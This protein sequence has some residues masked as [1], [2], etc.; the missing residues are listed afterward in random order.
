MNEESRLKAQGRLA[1]C[2]EI[3]RSY[4][5]MVQAAPH[6]LPGAA[7]QSECRQAITLLDR[8]QERLDR[9]LIVTIVGP[10]GAGKS[11]LLNA[12]AGSDDLSPV[13]IE[14]PTTRGVTVF[15]QS[16]SDADILLRDLGHE[17]VT[18]RTGG[19]VADGLD[20]VLLV[21]TPDMDS[22]ESQS[23]RTALEKTINMSDVLFC[24]L[25]AENPKRR[26]TIV[27]MR[28][29]VDLYPGNQLCVVLNRCDRL[30]ETELKQVILPD[31][32]KHLQESW[33]RPVEFVFCI[34]ARNNLQQP[35]WPDGEQPLHAY[36]DY[37]HLHEYVFGSLNRG[38]RFVDTRIERAEHLVD[39]I[40]KSAEDSVA[41]TEEKLK[42]VKTE[43][44]DLEKNAILAA[45]KTMQTTG[46]AMITGIHAIFYQKLAGRWWGPIG[47]LVGVWTRFLMAGAGVLATMRFG[48][49]VV[50]IWGLISSLVR[51]RKTRKA[52]TEAAAGGDMAPVLLKYRYTLQT[53]WPD[54][55]RKL[56]ELGFKPA[57]RDV[58]TVIPADRDLTRRLTSSWESTF[59]SVLDR[60]AGALSGFLLQLFFNLPTLALMGMFAYQSVK[61]YLFQQ[62]LPSGYFLH[63]G[64]SIFLVWILSFVLLQILVRF[65]GGTGLLNRAFAILVKEIQAGDKAGGSAALVQEIDTVLKLRQ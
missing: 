57:V 8:M 40:R 34:S 10:S 9:K 56:V 20:H 62:T 46:S 37:A 28:Q 33:Q 11:T 50:Q 7:L 24:V 13:G 12:L 29:Y 42:D 35:Q 53:V 51:Y 63:A 27:F 44:E 30:Q 45:T 6:W 41:T 60:R 23:Y 4:D 22:T 61:S 2:R 32:K 38:S 15:C 26:D 1:V 31:L 52:V 58:A 36:D 17:A 39:L 64:I 48:N 21:D 55:A 59:E 49:P 5:E 16:K 47:W 18:I 25:N 14:R 3:I 54:I 43:I 19:S 65:A